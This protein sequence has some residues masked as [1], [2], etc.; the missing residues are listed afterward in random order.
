MTNSHRNLPPE[1]HYKGQVG[2]Q[3]ERDGIWGWHFFHG[4]YVTVYWIEGAIL[5]RAMDGSGLE[6][7]M[8]NPWRL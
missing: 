5:V 6:E 2:T 3:G 4:T 1:F 8:E 7:T